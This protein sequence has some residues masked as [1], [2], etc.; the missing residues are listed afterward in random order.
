M[1]PNLIVIGAGKCGTTSLHLYLGLHPEISMTQQKELNFFVAE[2]NWRRG[3]GWYE[4]QFR[5]GTPVRGESSVAYSEY[6]QRQGVPERMAAL[7]P[8]VNIV[9]CVRDPFERMVS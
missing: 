4:E 1:L 2:L 9:Y 7:V 3:L 6:P 5:E 8:D